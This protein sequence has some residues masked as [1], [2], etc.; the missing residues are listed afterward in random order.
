VLFYA[1]NTT[2]AV[3]LSWAAALMFVACIRC[4]G[5]EK[6][7]RKEFYFYISQILLFF[8]VGL[9]DRFLF[10]ERIGRLFKMN[11]AY[12]VFILGIVEIV[13]FISLGNFKSLS[14]Y[15]RWHVYWA[16]L[17]FCI[18]F[19]VDVFVP[20]EAIFRLS[21]EDLSKTWGLLCVFLFAWGIFS[22]KIAA[23]KS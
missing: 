2:L 20:R 8:Y 6:E 9:D 18:M 15:L 14:R 4:I 5:R 12:F 13:L 10:H 3:F 19:V 23:L 21:I 16:A 7:K 22:E 11:D 17:F 1:V